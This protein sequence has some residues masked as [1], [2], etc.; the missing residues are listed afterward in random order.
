VQ[1]QQL[2]LATRQEG[3]ENPMTK[4]HTRKAPARKPRAGKR[5]FKLTFEAQD[6]LVDYTP[7]YMTGSDPTALFEFRSPHQPSWRIPVSATGY[8]SHFAPM[9]AVEAEPIP[10]EYARLAA[11]TFIRCAMKKP[12]GDADDEQPTLFG[13]LDA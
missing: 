10:E 11:L 12:A 8:R 6:M 1:Q 4:A 3:K 2:H 13:L 9:S 5:Q 7:D